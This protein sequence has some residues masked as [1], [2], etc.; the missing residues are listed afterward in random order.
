MLE[1]WVCSLSQEDPLAK[2]MG[3]HSSTRL[4]S[5]MNKEAWQATVHGVTKSWTQAGN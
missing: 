2:R 4:E 3:T 1:T 5:P